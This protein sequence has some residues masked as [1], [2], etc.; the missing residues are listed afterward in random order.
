MTIFSVEAACVR[1]RLIGRYKSALITPTTTSAANVILTAACLEG[2]NK[3]LR[4]HGDVAFIMKPWAARD[5]SV[6]HHPPSRNV[7]FQR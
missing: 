7:D 1:G 2:I 4:A 3:R 6:Q 5:A